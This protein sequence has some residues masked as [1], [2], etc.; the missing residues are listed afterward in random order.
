MD[1][2]EVGGCKGSVA[3]LGM[4][5][6]FWGPTVRAGLRSGDAGDAEEE[7]PVQQNMSAVYPAGRVALTLRAAQLD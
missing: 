4:S 5:G 2:G 1:A 6:M 7:L 3:R